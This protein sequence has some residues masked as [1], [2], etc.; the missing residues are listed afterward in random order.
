MASGR[1]LCHRNLVSVLED[2]SGETGSNCP[3]GEENPGWVSFFLFQREFHAG[4]IEDELKGRIS[5]T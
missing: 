4:G 5:A 2:G 1:H 3:P